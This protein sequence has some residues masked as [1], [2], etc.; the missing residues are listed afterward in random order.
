[1]CAEQTPRLTVAK[2]RETAPPPSSE[3]GKDA[4]VCALSSQNA[5]IYLN[6]DTAEK[7]LWVF[8]ISLSSTHGLIKNF[9]QNILNGKGL[10]GIEC[11][12]ASLNTHL[13][14]RPALHTHTH[15]SHILGLLDDLSSYVS[16]T[17]VSIP[18]P[19]SVR[20]WSY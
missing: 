5:I 4:C 1:M 7:V 6:Q 16:S 3:D 11:Q 15:T 13:E 2:A 17:L 19:E 18:S 20:P 12:N 10:M 8:F 9:G 14:N